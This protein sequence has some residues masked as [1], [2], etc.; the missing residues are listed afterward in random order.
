MSKFKTEN[1]YLLFIWRIL[2]VYIL[3]T[4]GRIFFIIYNY[5][6]LEPI[7][8]NQFFRIIL[9][10]LMFDTTAILYTNILILF[11][12][13]IPIPFVKT[14]IWQSVLRWL[15]III[16]FICLSINLADTVYF[17]F[18]M[19]RTSMTF[20]REFSGDVKF[21]KIFIESFSLYW[22]VFIL[23][24]LFLAILFFL[25]G[26]YHYP[27]GDALLKNNLKYVN[28]K[29]IFKRFYLYQSIALVITAPVF[30]I[31][32]RGGTTHAMKP[33]NINNAGDYVDRAIHMSAVLNTP[34]S[35]IR[36]IGKPDYKRINYY[37]SYE[38][39]SKIFSPIHNSSFSV[40]SIACSDTLNNNKIRILHSS[41]T[42]LKRNIVIVML[43]SFSAENMSFLNSN[44]D[45]N[46]TPFLDSLRKEGTLC[47]NAFANGR[48]SID[49][50]PSI[51]ASVPSL[52][53]QFAVS[54][55]S[56][57][58]LQGL[59]RILD[60]LGYYTAFFHGA[61]NN[62][63]GIRAVTNLCGI[64]H[65]FGKDQFGDNSK[66]DGS[67]GIWDEYFLQYV[68][69]ELPKLPQPFMA[70]VFTLSS[71]HPF[72][73][74][75]QYKNSLPKGET[76]LQTTIAYTDM[77]LRK[78][79]NK[80]SKQSWFKNTI[81]VI[82]PDHSTMQCNYPDYTSSLGTTS[83]PILYY[84]P[85]FIS[86]GIYSMPTQQIDI[87][88]T[89]LSLIGFKGSYFAFGRNLI[90]TSV[91]PYVINY[92]SDQF[93]LVLGD[94][95]LVRD[96]D[97]LSGVFMYKSDPQL[98]S[99]LLDGNGKSILDKNKL[100]KQDYFFKALIQ[101]YVNRLIDDRLTPNR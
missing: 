69:D 20:F 101:Q 2:L 73:L 6:L 77:S 10:G 19:R 82:T 56:T 50:V 15:Y 60:S 52:V 65:Y 12:A 62:S 36:T 14:H 76:P 4:A 11:L 67:W 92:G 9:G 46:Y 3:Y 17:G 33:I 86:K 88:P 16:N 98:Q 40:D 45:K 51:F 71:H 63:M 87:M 34:F 95:L 94:T 35:I 54:P 47:T 99:N 24:L 41:S 72:K 18:T 61:P 85:G 49:A 66:F 31:G 68:A 100:Y 80:I 83:I 55:Y 26:R 1:Y 37:D 27:N 91:N 23:G 25:S 13:F 7:S 21:F 28:H 90:D 59:P 42:A 53:Y 8:S 89:L 30:I 48:K 64:K 74:P 81:F 70:S 58:Q 5:N 78:F 96:R 22:Y 39:M 32:V 97:K 44:L 79:F 93:Q 29:G 84:S 57:D 43:E 75:Q 38:T